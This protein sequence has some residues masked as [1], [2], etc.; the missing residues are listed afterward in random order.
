M[1]VNYGSKL[2]S[3]TY[4]DQQSSEGLTVEDDQPVAVKCTFRGVK[5]QLQDGT[6]RVVFDIDPE[7]ITDFTLGFVVPGIGTPS[8]VA[9]LNPEA[10]QSQLQQE[11]IDK[12]NDYGDYAKALFKV[13]F[14]Q[15]PPVLAAL[16]T[17]ADFEDWTEHQRSA[18]SGAFSEYV[19][20]DGR[21]I[22]HHYRSV[23]NGAGTG[24]KPPYSTIPL[25]HDEHDRAHRGDDDMS[26][27]WQQKTLTKHRSAWGRVRLHDIFGVASLA[28]ISPDAMLEW[29]EANDIAQFLPR[30]YRE[31]G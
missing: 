11:M 3:N 17:D 31:H 26:H 8:I 7:D 6:L 16:G 15:A 25:T 4:I 19:N 2:Q 10:A 18:F 29:A 12:A 27:E 5:G 20:G 14:F 24:T 22:A 30:E 9:R 13:G 1:R 23:A 21:C 28:E